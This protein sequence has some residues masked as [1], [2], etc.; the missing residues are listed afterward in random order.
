ME[1]YQ[2]INGVISLTMGASW[3]SGINLYAALV[4]L[5][6]A[7]ATGN[8]DLP[9]GLEVLE[10]PLVIGAAGLMYITEFFADK[11]PGVDTTWD[12]LHTFVRIPAGALLA[13]GAVGDV[14]PALEI[15]AGILGGG[16]SATSHA[17]KAG[18]RLAVNTSPEPFSNIGVSL[19]ED[20]A[21]IGG[22]WAALTHPVVFL[23]LLA[24][25][26]CLAI[27][28]LPRIWRGVKFV[29]RKLGQLFG[30]VD[31][32]P[33]TVHTMPGPVL[34]PAGAGGDITSELERLKRLLD[35]GA[36]SAEEFETLKRRLL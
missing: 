15:A 10:N 17:V 8:V 4:M 13:M 1:E 27:W 9:P 20:V 30:V 2:S 12:A 16:L 3:A 21:V 29:F 28:L 19:A 11:I 5:G 14:T 26:L 34:S 23:V 36:I 32:E 33:P 18:T 7:G 31:K 22:L 25:F 35:D 24:I 6:F